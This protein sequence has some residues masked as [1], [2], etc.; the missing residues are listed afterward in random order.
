MQSRQPGEQGYLVTKEVTC[1]PWVGTL[2]GQCKWPTDL[3]D[4][5]GGERL[6]KW[7]LELIE[8]K[9][10]LYLIRDDEGVGID[11]R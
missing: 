3:I 6:D 4:S 2:R 9:F 10:H 8:I 1:I 7:N 5:Q 11:I